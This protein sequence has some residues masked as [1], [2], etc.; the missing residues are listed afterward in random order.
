[1]FNSIY[2]LR[3]ELHRR[4]ENILAR[5]IERINDHLPK[6][7]KTL[8]ELLSMEEPKVITRSGDV[9]II[10]RSELELLAKLVPSN[11]HDKFKLPIIILRM[12]E[13]GEGVYLICGGELEVQAIRK[14]LGDK[15]AVH[16]NDGKAFLYKPYVAILRGKLRTTTVIGFAAGM[17]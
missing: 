10:D 3:E 13:M 1:M 11:Y 14:V 17:E 5:E 12:I 2:D 4:F 8:K 6:E 9:L 7:S 15:E 16:Y